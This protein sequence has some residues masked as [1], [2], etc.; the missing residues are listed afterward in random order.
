MFFVFGAYPITNYIY[1]PIYAISESNEVLEY[2]NKWYLIMLFIGFAF[3]V[4]IAL[5]L[6]FL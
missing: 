4:S 1:A 6:I 5:N 3:P 2:W